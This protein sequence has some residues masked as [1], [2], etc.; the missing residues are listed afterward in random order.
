M[1]KKESQL[2]QCPQIAVIHRVQPA[3]RVE[4][5][6]AEVVESHGY[7]DGCA[8]AAVAERN[9]LNRTITVVIDDHVPI[10]IDHELVGIVEPSSNRNG[11]AVAATA[12]RNFDD[13]VATGV[14]YEQV[15]GRIPPQNTGVAE[16][17]SDRSRCAV[18]AVTEWQLLDG[19]AALGDI[20]DKQIS[21]RIHAKD[22]RVAE[23]PEAIVTAVP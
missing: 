5:H 1:F 19:R 8:V 23:A 22:R 17:G 10:A 7:R 9:F 15:T 2:H 3:P 20:D 13:G 14:A 21:R 4:N 6:A 12:E 16:A 18:A 11:R